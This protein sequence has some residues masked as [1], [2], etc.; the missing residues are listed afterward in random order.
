MEVLKALDLDLLN[1]NQ[2]EAVNVFNG[3]LLIAAGPGSGKTRVIAC[4]TAN[5]I[6]NNGIAPEEILLITFSKKAANEMQERIVG[7]IGEL[8]LPFIGTFHSLCLRILRTY[9]FKLSLNKNFKIYDPADQIHLMQK[10]I[11]DVKD[12]SL[13]ELLDRISVCKNNLLTPLE[14]PGEIQE[15]YRQYQSALKEE[16]AVDFDDIIFKT[17]QLLNKFPEVL[18]KLSFKYLMVD[19]Y[20]DTNKAQYEVLKLLAKRDKNICVIGDADQSIYAFRGANIRNFLNFGEDFT[21]LKLI[22]LEQNYRSSPQ[23]IKG[24]EAVI[25]GNSDHMQRNL[26]TEKAEGRR[27][28]LCN[29]S[30]EKAEADYIIKTIQVYMGGI[31]RYDIEA[32]RVSDVASGY[33]FSDFAVLYRTHMQGKILEELFLKSGIPFQQIGAENFYNKS[34]IKDVLCYLRA[35]FDPSDETALL[36]I[37]NKPVRGIGAV[38]IEKIRLYA[39]NLGIPFYQ[40]CQELDTLPLNDENKKSLAEFIKIFE[41]FRLMATKEKL[42]DLIKNICEKNQIFD[43]YKDK[44]RQDNIFGL[45][46]FSVQFDLLPPFKGLENFIFETAFMQDKD[47]YD[48]NKNAVTLLTLHASK[49]LE[50]PV[51]FI[52]G[53]EEGLIPYKHSEEVLMNEPEERRLFYV[54]M[55][56]AKDELHI[57]H[58]NE[59]NL[60]GENIKIELSRFVRDIPSEFLEKKEHVLKNRRKKSKNEDQLTIW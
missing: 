20:Q 29:A 11:H 26:W 24:A 3:P 18:E 42:S 17:Y 1:D 9:Y 45:L 12:K 47:I 25:E 37:I 36:R 59:R 22:K 41:E 5:M 60:F 58:T 21:D 10:I 48:E 54:G 13:R 34:E 33:G 16:N 55:T 23:I 2:R 53:A 46:G 39:K 6:I 51:V 52:A 50:F 8:N 14:A 49:G 7:M 43:L 30:N 19:E 38:T 27:V 4:R 56:R 57:I 31:S 35:V 32:D 44:K 15:A 40:A 28:V